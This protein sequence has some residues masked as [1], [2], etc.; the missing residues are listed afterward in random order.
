[1]KKILLITL[2]NL[3]DIILTTPVLRRLCDEFPEASVDVITGEPGRE[4]FSRHPRVSNVMVPARK[5]TLF[6]R[7]EE[8]RDLRREHYDVVVDLKRSLVPLLAG[9][10]RNSSFFLRNRGGLHKTDEHLMRLK[11][12]GIRD[13]LSE[14]KF[15]LPSNE[16]ERGYIDRVIG[17]DWTRIVVINAGAK[18]HLKRWAPEKFAALSDLL[19]SRLKCRVV[20]TGAD[21]DTEVTSRIAGLVTTPVKDLCAR[22]TIGALAELMSRSD[23]VVTNDSAPLHVASAVNAPTIAIFGPTSEKKYGP[24]ADKNITV[25]PS[26][27]CRPCEKALCGKGNTDGC[28]G[29]I[30]VEEVFRPAGRLLGGNV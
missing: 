18:S 24:L 20:L 16:A 4:I 11:G 28:I 8:V 14:K 30:S 29:D 23:L 21:E 7:A 15:F 17:S 10:G 25:S 2:S 19:V 26:V 13:P 12:V 3:G 22:T 27:K 5:R 9:A 1:M 6:Q